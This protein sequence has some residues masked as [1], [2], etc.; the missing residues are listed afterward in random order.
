MCDNLANA[1]F[2]IGAAASFD[3]G[4]DS[5]VGCIA[6]HAILD[7]VRYVAERSNDTPLDAVFVAC[8][9]LKCAPV[10]AEAE[11]VIGIPVISS[12]SALAW[13]MARLANLDIGAAGK[14]AL[15]S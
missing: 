2:S 5:V 7:A 1:G 11:A 13:D 6:P 10:I 3:E 15:Y 12:N 4:R 9:S 14:V 8:T